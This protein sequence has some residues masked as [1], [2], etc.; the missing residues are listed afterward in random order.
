MSDRLRLLEDKIEELKQASADLQAEIRE[1]HE[2]TKRLRELKKETERY[3]ETEARK[4]VDA[5]IADAV[6]SGLEGYQET[7]KKQTEIATN[8]VFR[9]FDD[10]A[11]VMLTGK[12]SGDGPVLGS[13]AFFL[14]TK[15]KGK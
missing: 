7:I 13:E 8:A 6:K 9:R 3:L 11:N 4:I 14:E 1:A 5:A 2:A 10:L 15:K 12:K